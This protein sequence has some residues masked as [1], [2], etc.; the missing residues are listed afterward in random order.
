MRTYPFL[1]SYVITQT[2]DHKIPSYRRPPKKT[3]SYRRRPVSIA[4]QGPCYNPDSGVRPRNDTYEKFRNT[5][6]NNRIFII[7]GLIGQSRNTKETQ[8]IPACAGMTTK[9]NKAPPMENQETLSHQAHSPVTPSRTRFTSGV[10]G[11][12]NHSLK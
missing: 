2:P 7:G 3:P 8:W 1:G 10:P 9:N 12:R 11:W 4:P 6:P 5:N